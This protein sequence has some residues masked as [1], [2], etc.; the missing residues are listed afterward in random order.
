MTEGL[1]KK[2]I[3]V[4][5]GLFTWPSDNPQLI[6]T[7]CIS[8][9]SIYFPNKQSC[10]N[11]KCKEKKVQEILLNTE[12]TLW[13]FTVMRYPPSPPFKTDKK[14]PY[15]VG[16]IEL[17]EGIRV[18]GLLTEC[19]YEEL[20]IGMKMKLAIE[21]LFTNED[22]QEVVTWKFKPIDKNK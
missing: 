18:L 5:D 3:P 9:N 13:S 15:P 14:P 6:G 10:N 22:G 7:K 16:I 12:G 4:I 21:R 11:P 20:T 2:S 1:A 17:P 8:C 19:K